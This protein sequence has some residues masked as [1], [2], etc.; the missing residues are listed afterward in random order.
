M[1]YP[2]AY[3]MTPSAPPPM[4]Y[5]PAY[6]MTPPAPPPKKPTSVLR[7]IGGAIVLAAIVVGF[8]L[9]RPFMQNDANALQVGDCFDRPTSTS[10]IKSVQNHPCSD[11]HDAEVIAVVDHPDAKGATYPAS[12]AFST[13]AAV[14]CVP[15]F[16]AYTKLDFNTQPD[17]DMGFLYPTSAAWSSGDRRVT[18]YLYR[19][20]EQK[21][22]GS[23]KAAS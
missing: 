22:T 16:N 1:E 13:F 14:Q 18:C 20:D 9:L 8:I 10:D 3:P 15:A 5:P 7:L 4:A 21:F 6:P 11:A 23:K 2:P 12:A 19:L 17:L